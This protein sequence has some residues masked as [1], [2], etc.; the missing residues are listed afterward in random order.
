MLF[1][2]VCLIYLKKAHCLSFKSRHKKLD[3]VVIWKNKSRISL[4]QTWKKVKLEFLGQPIPSLPY[5]LPLMFL[6][7]AS[8]FL[9][10]VS[11]LLLPEV[12]NY[13]DFLILE[14][15]SYD[16]DVFSSLLL[17]LCPSPPLRSN[18]WLMW[19]NGQY[20]FPSNWDF[21]FLFQRNSLTW[22]SR[23]CGHV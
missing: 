22:Y 17:I 4:R 7:V 11:L 9:R 13:Y 8:C 10:L 18:L 14:T 15:A 1:F 2:C 5:F 12:L 23:I 21:F 20:L 19:L 16:L 3:S 6:S